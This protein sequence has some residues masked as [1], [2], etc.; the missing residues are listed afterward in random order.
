MNKQT[1][2]TILECALLKFD[3]VTE[4]DMI[5]NYGL[6]KQLVSVGCKLCDYLKKIK[7]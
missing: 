3:G 4:N 2:S 6:N 7:C 5:L 1:F